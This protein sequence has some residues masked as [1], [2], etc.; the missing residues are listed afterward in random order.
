MEDSPNA[1]YTLERLLRDSSDA[2]TALQAVGK[3]H[4][5]MSESGAGMA[6]AQ[7]ALSETL[8]TGSFCK[9]TGDA[10]AV[11]AAL[12]EV[13]SLQESLYAGLARKGPDNCDVGKTLSRRSRTVAEKRRVYEGAQSKYL[14]AQSR[15]CTLSAKEDGERLRAADEDAESHRRDAEMR[16]IDLKH[17]LEKTTLAYRT[18]HA[19]LL[20]ATVETHLPF[21]RAAVAALERAAPSLSALQDALAASRAEL[22]AEQRAERERATRTHD[23]DVPRSRSTPGR[24][25]SFNNVWTRSPA[26]GWGSAA[27]GRVGEAGVGA[28]AGGGGRGS[29]AAAAPPPSPSPEGGR[30]QTPEQQP[31]VGLEGGRRREGLLYAHGGG[32][33]ARCWM[34]SDGDSAMWWLAADHSRRGM[35]GAPLGGAIDVAGPPKRTMPLQLCTVKVGA[36]AAEQEGGSKAPHSRFV[37]S[38]VSAKGVGLF[39]ATTERSAAA[40][41]A[42]LRAGILHSLEGGASCH[43]AT[44]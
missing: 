16:R 26:G 14:A 2:G 39:Q 15:A 6:K 13:S 4:H 40:W 43:G 10:D 31:E 20:A 11:C 12:L 19:T 38:L 9:G 29:S 33:W 35:H 25:S 22:L 5:R 24:R 34:V 18:E 27:D 3:S 21:F 8:N 32:G 28:E 30:E 17:E 42:T 41:V 37:F 36:G 23:G 1:F 7:R 44:C